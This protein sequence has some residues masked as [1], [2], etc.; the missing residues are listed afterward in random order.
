M[1]WLF[2]SMPAAGGGGH[3]SVENPG[4]RGTHETHTLV[5][6]PGQPV[7]YR[8]P[9]RVSGGIPPYESVIQGCPGWVVLFPDQGILAGVAPVGAGGTYFCIYRV[10]E[11]DPG[12]RP[13]RS[14]TY[15]LRLEVGEGDSATMS[16]DPSYHLGSARFTTHQPVVLEQVG[17]HHAYARGLTGRDVRIG[18]DDS[19]VDYTQTDEFGNRVRLRASDGAQLSYSHPFGDDASSSVDLCR[20]NRTCT[21]ERRDSQGDEEAHNRWVREI[22]SRGGWPT[23]DDSV[24]IVDEHY[25]EEDAL[26]RL[27][28]WWEVPTPYGE[29]GSHGTAVASVAAGKNLGVAP[30]ATIIPVARNFSPDE[31][32]EEGLA[33]ADLRS[34][35]ALLGS[36][37]LREL[38]DAL[39]SV[40]R[41]DYAR[42]DIINRSY[43]IPEFDPDTVSS[44]IA[45][46]LQWYRQYLP[47][48]LDA[49]LQVG[50]PDPRKTV[51]VYAAGNEGQP[52]PGFSAYLP[53]HIPELHGHSLAVAATDPRTGSIAD[54][55]NR[56]GSLPRDWNAARH[57]RHYCLVAPGTAR[58]LLPDPDS[59]GRG[60]VG[61]V[62]GTSIAAP[63]VS[64]ALALLMEHFRGTRGNTE[65]VK[66]MMDTADRRGRYSDL[67]TYG[68]GHLD[69]AAALSPVGSLNAGQSARAL[70]R[71]SLRTPAAFG[72]L[73]RRASG[74]ELA[75]FDAQD[76]PFWVPLSGLV[77]AHSNGRSPIPEFVD[78]KPADVAAPGLD[79]LGLHWVALDP[80]GSIQ[81]PGER[82]WMVGLGETSASLARLPDNGEWGY[83]VSFDDAGYLESETSGAFGS[84]PR[85]GMIWTSRAFER[86]LGA[87]LTL[88]ASGTLAF[89]L[90]R[91]EGDA[92]F[93]ASPSIMSAMST[94]IGTEST[95]FTVEQPLRAESGTGTFRVEN[96]RVENGRRL[97]DIHRVPLRPDARELRFALRHERAAFGGNIAVEI[98]HS[99]NV[100]HVSGESETAFGLAYRITW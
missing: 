74:I 43:G 29:H 9:F 77:S 38:D 31:Q 13:A 94:R 1:S 53:Y 69:I 40:Y 70:S 76:F 15:G 82:E 24:F 16:S 25:S 4:G 6:I 68:A 55:S 48:T 33:D 34:A 72:S 30:E 90:P 12:F 50:T 67:A 10:T 45:S 39:A 95:G 44:A 21:V 27:L 63:I 28:R 2:R 64:G 32:W 59:P 22:V 47:N 89:S 66:R 54:Y 8:L 96:G 49:L 11:S 41:E 85:S 83:G 86:E 60:V 80:A 7:E 87:G 20:G 58:G 91:Y 26:E 99:T 62:S 79:G 35:I 14:V 5:F 19:V 42:F 75:A 97:Y 18:I 37:E 57:G 56:C 100:G 81:F 17:A 71:T 93:S 61:E 92:L 46:E 3:L 23:R 52:H 78:R 98:G 88:N 51:L 73:G 36:A 84:D 65:I